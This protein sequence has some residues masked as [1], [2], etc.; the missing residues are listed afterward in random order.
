MAWHRVNDC[1]DMRG[2]KAAY[3]TPRWV[4]QLGSEYL[5]VWARSLESALDECV[6]WA[7]E[8]AP[9]LLCDSEVAEEC[10]RLEADGMSTERAY[11][12]ATVD[13]TC[14]GNCGNYIHSDDWSVVAEDPDR[15]TLLELRR[16]CA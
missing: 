5:L 7:A 8:H 16:R 9:G 12:L 15:A 3:R 11:E 14:A 4:L 6:D 10:Q 1:P 2:T 13:T